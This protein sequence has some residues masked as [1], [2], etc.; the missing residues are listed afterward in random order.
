MFLMQGLMMHSYLCSHIPVTSQQK[1]SSEGV[2][3]VDLTSQ[4]HFLDFGMSCVLNGSSYELKPCVQLISYFSGLFSQFLDEWMHNYK[5]SKFHLKIALT[6][7]ECFG[8][9]FTGSEYVH[10]LPQSVRFNSSN[11]KMQFWFL[12]CMVVFMFALEAEC[13]KT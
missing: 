7:T 11:Y 10:F 6:H 2:F 8:R 5:S 12:H 9:L 1:A 13:P 3:P 4:E